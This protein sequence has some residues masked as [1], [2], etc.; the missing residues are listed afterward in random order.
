VGTLFL[1][2]AAA[3]VALQ[4]PDIVTTNRVVAMGGR[5]V[6]PLM[7]KLMEATGLWWVPKIALVA[8]GAAVLVAIGDAWSLAALVIIDAGYAVVVVHNLRVMNR[9]R[10]NREELEAAYRRWLGPG[11]GTG[12]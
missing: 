9:M 12:T 5:E 6:N 2:L 3:A 7:R 1:I 10:R 8:A 4:I 11:G